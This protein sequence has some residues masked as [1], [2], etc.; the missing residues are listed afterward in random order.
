MTPTNTEV[1]L[2]KR[3]SEPSFL[4]L[5]LTTRQSGIL[6]FQPNQLEVRQAMEYRMGWLAIHCTWHYN[7]TTLSWFVFIDTVVLRWFV[8][9]WPQIW[10]ATLS[11]D[12]LRLKIS[13]KI[14]HHWCASWRQKTA[15]LGLH[16]NKA[17]KKSIAYLVKYSTYSTAN[18]QQ[19]YLHYDW[20]SLYDDSS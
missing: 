6:R 2:I 15:K 11:I 18:N 4:F 1:H 19:S 16:H 8:L 5:L 12:R 7:D 9:S 13:C 17:W 10:M 14:H 3:P 20:L